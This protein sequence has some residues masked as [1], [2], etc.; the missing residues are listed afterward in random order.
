MSSVWIWKTV[1]I[2]PSHPVLRYIFGLLEYYQILK[3]K[4][5]VFIYFYST[6]PHQVTHCATGVG[7][8]GSCFLFFSI[9][10]RNGW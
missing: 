10:Y 4:S 7:Q 5:S 3:M 6:V 9:V 8:S 1:E 2:V